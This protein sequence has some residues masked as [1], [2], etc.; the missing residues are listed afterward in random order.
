MKLAV[1]SRWIGRTCYSSGRTWNLLGHCLAS[2]S[3]AV[4]AWIPYSVSNVVKWTLPG[5]ETRAITSLMSRFSLLSW[6][7]PLAKKRRWIENFESSWFL[8]PAIYLRGLMCL[9]SGC[10]I[11]TSR[12]EFCSIQVFIIFRWSDLHRNGTSLCLLRLSLVTLAVR[13]D[14]ISALSIL[15]VGW[16]PCVRYV[17]M[18]CPTIFWHAHYT[19]D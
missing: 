13:L 14:A 16:K 12:V 6:T 18:I 11:L 10:T 8:F 1:S 4:D 9:A 19:V 3:D 15:Y 7:T 2:R 17:D 5:E